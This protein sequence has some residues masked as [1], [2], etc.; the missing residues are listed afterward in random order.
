MQH[1]RLTLGLLLVLVGVGRAADWPLTGTLGAHDPSPIKQ[2][3][4]WWCFVTGA[5]LRVKTSPDGLNWMQSTPLFATELDWWRKYAPAMRQLDVWAPDIHEF[6]GRVWCYYSVSEFGRNN[7]AIGLKSC[8]SLAAGDW[9]DDGLV[10]N[11]R[12]GQDAYNAIDPFLT[13]DREGRPWLT[14]GSWFDGIQIVALDS[15]TMKPSGPIRCVARRENGIEGPNIVY[16]NGHYYLFVSIDK[17]CQGVNST[18]K[19]V[20]GRSERI[21]GPYVDKAGIA[22]LEGGG[23]VLE[24]GSERWKGPGGQ[25]V[26]KN[27]DLWA[28]ARHAYDPQN[29]G[30]PMLLISDLFWDADGWP[31]LT[32]S[33]G[34]S[35]SPN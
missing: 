10:I 21:T 1:R 34:S 6:G 9:R 23:T 16:A 14:F 11:S 2:G 5:G 12:R 8:T 27:G 7:S 26:F 15:A 4:A 32:A 31:V 3:D 19:I 33:V 28:I 29:N 22:L 35:G 30:R 13:T 17:C 18:Y 24:A 20:Y 25:R